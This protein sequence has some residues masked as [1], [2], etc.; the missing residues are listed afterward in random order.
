MTWKKRGIAPIL[1]NPYFLIAVL[2]VIGF[3]VFSSGSGFKL[4][5]FSDVD[6]AGFTFKDS[7]PVQT[8]SCNYGGSGSDVTKEG[9]FLILSSSGTRPNFRTLT[10]DV[11]GVDEVL[12]IYDGYVS[13]SC[14]KYQ[15]GGYGSVSASI[16]G[17]TSGSIEES[18]SAG[19]NPNSQ[20]FSEKYIAPSIWKF[21][22]NFDGTWSTLQS[23]NVGDVFIEKTKAPISGD[24][25]FLSLKVSGGVGA[26]QGSNGPA[27]GSAKLKIYNIVRKENAFAV[28]KADQF[29]QDVNKD[30]KIATDGSECFDLQTIV[31]NSEESIKES[32]DEKIARITAE[33]EAKN[34]GL[35]AQLDQLKQQL[36]ST[37]SS[38]QLTDLQK[39][40]A[41]L[42]AQL[43]T[44]QDKTAIQAQIDAL[45]QQQLESSNVEDRIAA[46]EAELKETKDVLASV[47]AEDKAVIN[48]IENQAQFEK[49]GF[50]KTLLNKLIAFIKGIFP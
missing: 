48:T 47:Q 2:L 17:S 44:A 46:L 35:Q 36:D 7:G 32:Y 45:R 26:C 16:T 5:I 15:G 6:F 10:T 1:L 4:A 41:S 29:V 40:I 23:L 27:S 34:T 18:D 42:E 14:S 8:G 33:L 11:T 21:R 22:N 19:C 9:E 25:Q 24:K 3:F 12:I 28:C 37:D 31:L 38:T 13:A 39:Q 49:P 20:L 43:T 50:F 30:G